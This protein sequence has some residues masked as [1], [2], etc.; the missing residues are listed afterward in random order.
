MTKQDADSTVRYVNNMVRQHTEPVVKYSVEYME[1]NGLLALNIAVAP[2]KA[3]VW[4]KDSKTQP[5]IYVCDEGGTRL[6]TIAE[7]QDMLQ[8]LEIYNFD[9]TPTG[10]KFSEVSF[11]E[12]E[13]AYRR[14]NNKEELTTQMLKSFE[15]VTPDDYLTIAGLIFCDDSKYENM[16]MVCTTWHGKDKSSL[17]YTDS[18]EYC[19][20]AIQI[21]R[22]GI[23][24][25]HSLMDHKTEMMN[26]VGQ[27]L[28]Q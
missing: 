4:L 18:K 28:R 5:L 19:G 15:L 24:Y 20:S 11:G 7:M 13:E 23:D 16:R 3:V 6:A 27:L 8:K 10:I 21:I 26:K 12:L 14:N 2:S 25:A 17:R 22:N 1:R 9:R